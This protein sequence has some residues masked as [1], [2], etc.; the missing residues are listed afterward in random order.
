MDLRK[1]IIV[2]VGA[3]GVGKTFVAAGLKHELEAR[4]ERVE[5]FDDY[6]IPN[7][8]L[9]EDIEHALV[10]RSARVIVTVKSPEQITLLPFRILKTITSIEC[11]Q[12]RGVGRKESA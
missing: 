2:I 6:K 10:R 12:F 4:G 7:A 8:S 1:G 3:V 11:V 9:F 5:V